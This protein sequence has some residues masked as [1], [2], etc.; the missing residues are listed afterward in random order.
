MEDALMARLRSRLLVALDAGS[1]AGTVAYPGIGAARL[2]AWVRVPLPEGALRP[3]I[4]E[5]NVVDP[6]AVV[7]ALAAVCEGL[8]ARR[9]DAVLVLPE[10][11]AR[12][13]LLE[14]PRG[15]DVREFA[16]FRMAQAL[17]YPGAEAIIDFLAVARGRYLCGAVQRNVAQSYEAL[18][19]AG[20]FR[21][22]RVDVAPLVATA[23]LKRLTG[24]GEAGVA[25]LLGDVSLSIAAFARGKLAAFRTRLR[26]PGAGEAE[27]LV[28]E[29]SRTTGL[30]GSPNLGRILVL[31]SD[32]RRVAQSLR[33]LGCDAISTAT[34]A[35]GEEGSESADRA[36]MGA[37]LA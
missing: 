15:V 34:G 35:A 9:R 1:V 7:A 33:S 2:G 19:E 31:G 37:A 18:V 30:A 29:L 36:W 5:A 21:V 20:G 28:E 27:W 26:A 17:P 24:P 12:L 14:A 11:V 4:V 16:R 25:L 13:A 8:G 23:S 22:D 10:G 32:A 6:Q 3:S